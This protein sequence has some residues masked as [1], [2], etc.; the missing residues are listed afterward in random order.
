MITMIRDP[1]SISHHEHVA[2]ALPQTRLAP[3]L[4][5]FWVLYLLKNLLVMLTQSFLLTPIHQIH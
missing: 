3:N 5:D 4:S 1:N 2:L